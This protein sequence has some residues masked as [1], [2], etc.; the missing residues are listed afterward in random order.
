MRISAHVIAIIPSA[1]YPAHSLKDATR[2]PAPQ[3]GS[4]RRHVFAAWSMNSG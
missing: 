2:W 4:P 1:S 3:S